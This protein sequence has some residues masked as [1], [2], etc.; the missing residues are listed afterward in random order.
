MVYWES[1]D[2]AVGTAT[3]YGPEGF[4]FESR[5]GARFSARFQ[6]GPEAYPASYT[7]VTGSLPGVK[8]PGLGV[9][10]YYLRFLTLFVVFWGR[11]GCWIGYDTFFVIICFLYIGIVLLHSLVLYGLWLL[12]HL[13]VSSL[14]VVYRAMRISYS[15]GQV[16][17]S[18][19]VYI[20]LF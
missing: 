8:R 19:R 5:C 12:S 3:R 4:G 20:N 7:M 13:R 10:Q 11:R 15:G 18:V 2:G 14:G 9:Y 1:R 6:I 16:L 17:Y